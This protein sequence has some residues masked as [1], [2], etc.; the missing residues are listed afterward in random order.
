MEANKI[1]QADY[2]DILFDEKNKTYGAY[3]LRKSY[4]KRLTTAIAGMFSILLLFF[5]GSVLANSLAKKQVVAQE[6]TTDVILEQVKKPQEEI[7]LP[8][9]P[10]VKV[11]PVENLKTIS[12]TP[13]LI[14]PDEDVSENEKPPLNEDIADIKISNV[15]NN[16]GVDGDIVAP[17]L[18]LDNGTGVTVSIQ[19]K[20]EDYEG[21]FV[22]VQNPARFKGGAD[23]WK[24]YLERNLNYPD[25]AQEKGTQATVKVQLVVDKDGK[26]SDVHALNNPGDGLA[27]EAIRIIKKCPDWIPA[28]QNGNKVSYRFIQSVAFTLN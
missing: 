18:N 11:Q 9:P 1:L 22:T 15:T 25:E 19:P 2:L 5:F 10:E 27:E 8:P 16:D 7:K 23:A 21:I 6:V 17:P 20:K 13:P 26:V 12:V 4:N 14:T 24:R 28:E 3:Q